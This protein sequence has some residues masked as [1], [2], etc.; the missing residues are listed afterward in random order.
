MKEELEATP[1][2]GSWLLAVILIITAAG[3]VDRGH[4]R[5]AGVLGLGSLALILFG[6]CGT[7]AGGLG[8]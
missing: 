2:Y 7:G 4:R 8:P 5:V 1:V 6:M 3:S